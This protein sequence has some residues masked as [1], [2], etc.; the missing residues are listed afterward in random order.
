MW[1]G[2]IGRRISALLFGRVNLSDAIGYNDQLN[3][4]QVRPLPPQSNSTG[5]GF[6]QPQRRNKL[7][8][9]CQKCG[10]KFKLD[11]I[12]SNDLWGKIKPKEKQQ[13]SG[14]YCGCCIIKKIEGLLGYSK[15]NLLSDDE[16]IIERLKGFQQGISKA[17]G[18]KEQ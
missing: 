16:L 15:F 10:E 13:D 18:G 1:G 11:L 2:G 12:I 3:S 5:A 7:S 8:C 6:G 9:V 17:L 4:V 14:I